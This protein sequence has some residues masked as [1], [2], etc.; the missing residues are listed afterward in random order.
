MIYA[1][2]KFYKTKWKRID[3]CSVLFFD[4][5]ECMLLFCVAANQ[6]HCQHCSPLSESD[7]KSWHRYIDFLVSNWDDKFDSPSFYEDIKRR[8]YCC[9]ATENSQCRLKL[10]RQSKKEPKLYY[11]VE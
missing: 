2:D 8:P 11:N 5:M 10:I 9:N 3:W 6:S 1:T 7:Q 4:T